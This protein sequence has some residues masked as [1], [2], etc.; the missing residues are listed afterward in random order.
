MKPRSREIGNSNYGITLKHFRITGLCAGN[1]P[2]SGE[3]PSQRPVTRIFDVF[4]DLVLNKR[5]GKQSW[6]WWFETL[7]CPLWRHCNECIYTLTAVMFGIFIQTAWCDAVTRHV[8]PCTESKEFVWLITA[9]RKDIALCFN[10]DSSKP[11]LVLI[12][13]WILNSYMYISMCHLIIHQYS[14]INKYG[15]YKTLQCNY[16]PISTVRFPARMCTHIQQK[17]MD[18]SLIST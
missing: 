14:Y 6:G 10:T 8:N 16:S 18:E 1:S 15:V 2:V 4:F 5:L 9:F 13:K 7:S 17:A 12:H 3:F 11:L